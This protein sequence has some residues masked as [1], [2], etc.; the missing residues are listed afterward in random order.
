MKLANT[1][2]LVFMMAMSIFAHAAY[3][4]TNSVKVNQ[5]SVWTNTGSI[6]V[7]TTPRPDISGLNCSN[8]YWLVLD[9]NDAGYQAALSMLLSAQAT[10]KSV[11][12]S[13][14]ENGGGECCRLR[15]VVNLSN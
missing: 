1:L 4:D 13:A 14:E 9:K 11:N 8:D 12:V 2:A 3:K 10:Q 15:R 7:Q 6:L 5:I